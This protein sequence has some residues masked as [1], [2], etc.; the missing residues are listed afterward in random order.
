MREDENVV[1]NRPPSQYIEGV[2]LQP[3]AHQVGGHGSVFKVQ[4]KLCKPAVERELK[5]YQS[6]DANSPLR[7]WVPK[8]Y[9]VVRLKFDIEE[10]TLASSWNSSTAGPPSRELASADIDADG[11]DETSDE[12]SSLNSMQSPAS[13]LS[14]TDDGTDVPELQLDH[15]QSNSMLGTH[16]PLRKSLAS[17]AGSRKPHMVGRGQQHH[18]THPTGDHGL[19]QDG[20]LTAP[21]PHSAGLMR[22]NNSHRQFLERGSPQGLNANPWS[23]QC[24]KKLLSNIDRGSPD[25]STAGVPDSNQRYVMLEDLTKKFECPC[26]LDLKMGTRQHGLDVSDAKAKRQTEK[27]AR[28]TSLPLGV[29]LCGMQ[30]YNPRAQSFFCRDKYYGRRLK[31]DD[32]P[33]AVA[34][35]VYNTIEVRRDVVTEIIRQLRELREVLR[36]LHTYRFFSC[37]LLILYEGDPDLVSQVDVRYID[38]A[39]AVTDFANHDDQPDLGH[40][41]GLDTLIGVFESIRDGMID[42]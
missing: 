4:D 37:S 10:G 26:I 3:F 32:F 33:K 39:H 29:R 41:Q 34:E 27:C 13:M 5:F 6:Q 42:A 2:K 36:N 24:F 16:S 28:T 30:V 25:G 14:Q 11:A 31:V 15:Q 9:G 19:S 40:I 1:E 8:Y 12:V 23:L 35:F 22:R 17:A 38:F 21:A 18:Y 7:K 20:S